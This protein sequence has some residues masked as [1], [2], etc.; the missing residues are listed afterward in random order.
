MRR[1][2]SAPTAGWTI[3]VRSARAAASANTMSATACRSSAPSGPRIGRTEPLDHGDQH[4]LP[5][6]LQLVHDGVGVDH[7]RPP[8][9][10]QPGHGRLAGADAAGQTDQLHPSPSPMSPS[11]RGRARRLAAV[12]GERLRRSRT[13]HRA[14]GGR[15]PPPAISSGRPNRRNLCSCTIAAATSSMPGMPKTSAAHR[16]VDEAGTDRVG[17]MPGGP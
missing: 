8:F 4:R 2:I 6:R 17:R 15:R 10:E 5:G 13:T 14:T 11:R 16:R 12:D 9:G 3:A 1:V 7:H